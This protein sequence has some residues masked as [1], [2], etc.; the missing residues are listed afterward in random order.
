MFEFTNPPIYI[1]YSLLTD[2]GIARWILTLDQ[3]QDPVFNEAV[4]T[5][6]VQYKLISRGISV[7]ARLYGEEIF[8]DDKIKIRDKES[9]LFL[10]CGRWV[11]VINNNI[12]PLNTILDIS[13]IVSP[14]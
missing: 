9:P 10:D 11:C 1:R 12:L 5:W 4:N 14:T 6:L 13:T 7:G 8:S 2:K 3:L